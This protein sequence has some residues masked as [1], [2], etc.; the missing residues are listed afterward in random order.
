MRGKFITLEGPEGCGKTTHA[1]LLA[2]ALRA[3]SIEVVETREPGGTPLAEKIRALVREQSGDP[4][5]PEAETLLFLAARAQNDRNVLR[6][7]LERGAWVVCDRFSD[8]TFAY[9][10]FGRGLDIDALARLNDFATCGLEPDL[11]ILLDIPPETSRARLSRREADSGERADRMESAGDAFHRAV[12]EGFLA[13]AR[14]P[15]NSARFA[16]VDS[17]RPQEEVSAGIFAAVARLAETATALKGA[18]AS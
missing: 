9:Q 6:P 8:S 7:A 16:V 15:E 18:E 1:R 11:T 3:R 10:G 14:R 12:R 17:S 5:G 4:P 2:A 13:L